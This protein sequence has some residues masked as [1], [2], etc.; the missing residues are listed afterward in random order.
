MRFLS[1]T[2]RKAPAAVSAVS[3]ATTMGGSVS[4]D[5]PEITYTPPAGFTGLDTFAVTIVDGQGG[6]VE[7][8]ITIFISSN[9]P[10]EAIPAQMAIQPD[11]NVALLFQVLPGQ[12]SAI[13]RSTNLSAW[14]TLL[15]SVADAAGLLP[16]TDNAPQTGYFYRAVAE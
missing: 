8:T 11:G 9:D 12:P 16:F 6:T 5:G 13:Q 2:H 3:A 4:L 1:D 14:T 15:S 7:G 10:S